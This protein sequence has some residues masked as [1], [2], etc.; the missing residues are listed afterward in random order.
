VPLVGG[1]R[2]DEDFCIGHVK[3]LREVLLEQKKP[4]GL[5]CYTYKNWSMP[6]PGLGALESHFN[7]EN[8]NRWNKLEETYK[9]ICSEFNEIKIK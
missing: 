3:G 2:A 6:A 7:P 5:F 4:G 9:E 1:K 8:P